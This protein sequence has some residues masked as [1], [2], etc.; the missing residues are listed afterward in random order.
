[1]AFS[2]DGTVWPPLDRAGPAV[3]APLRC[4]M[5]GGEEVVSGRTPVAAVFEGDYP[6]S[7]AVQA[8]VRG[9]GY[10]VVSFEERPVDV[11]AT[12]KSLG[13]DLVVLELAMVGALGLHVVRDVVEAVPG[14]TVILLSPFETLREPAVAAGAFELVGNNLQALDLCLGRLSAPERSESASASASDAE[15]SPMSS[16]ARPSA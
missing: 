11:A 8:M 3:P 4:P 10:S 12:V 5:K 13:A 15:S 9:R 16:G 6:T 2:S 7:R 14:C 1:M